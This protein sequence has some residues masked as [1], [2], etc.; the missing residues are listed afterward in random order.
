MATR[1]RG[2]I[3]K[4]KNAER[5]IVAML[6]PILNDLFAGVGRDAPVLQRN[7]LQSDTGGA[8]LCGL[9]WLALE[10]KCCE[11]FNLPAWWTQCAGQAKRNQTPVLF[12]RRNN[13][14]WRVRMRGY[15]QDRLMPE[16][17]LE[18]L[19]DIEVDAF[20]AYFRERVAKELEETGAVKEEVKSLT[21]RAEEYCAKLGFP[22]PKRK[23]AEHKTMVDWFSRI[24]GTN[25]IV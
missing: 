16:V 6:Q 14:K 2:S 13:V 22:I 1:G 8:D 11:T 17:R 3:Q 5:E 21:M 4:G 12:Y 10:V 24:E 9:S 7:T 20:L 23:T 19:V 18:C 15:A 25:T